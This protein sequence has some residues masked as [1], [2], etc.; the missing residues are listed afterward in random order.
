[1]EPGE[2]HGVERHVDEPKPFYSADIIDHHTAIIERAIRVSLLIEK[3]S[4]GE[5]EHLLETKDH[6]VPSLRSFESYIEQYANHEDMDL[7]CDALTEVD[8]LQVKALVVSEGISYI[9]AL[10]SLKNLE[11]LT[12]NGARLSELSALAK[13]RKLTSLDVRVG[14]GDILNFPSDGNTGP[15]SD[16]SHLSKL[17]RLE[18]LDVSFHNIHDLTP[19]S[20]LNRLSRLHLGSN[21]ITDLSPLSG[22]DRLERLILNNNQIQHLGPLAKLKKLNFLVEV[23]KSTDPF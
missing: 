13:L 10:A 7:E 5:K 20:G 15:L 16:I 17:T 23:K 1:M 14:A 12:L 18:F 22:L 11:H 2:N 3:L 9:K 19:L 4:P 6:A 21:R 8:L